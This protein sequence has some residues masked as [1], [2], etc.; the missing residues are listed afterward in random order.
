MEYETWYL[1]LQNFRKTCKVQ[2]ADKIFNT[3]IVV[4]GRAVVFK[5]S[6]Y[7]LLKLPCHKRNDEHIKLFTPQLMQH[8]F[9]EERQMGQS[10]ICDV[11]KCVQLCEVP[12]N[13]DLFRHG[14]V[15]YNFYLI[16]DG[17]VEVH[18]PDP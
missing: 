11:L 1:R 17:I 15:G 10:E 14:D 7:Q 9:F 6:L 3:V 2:I 5:E 16:L 18:I 12:A 13:E 4:E 8:K